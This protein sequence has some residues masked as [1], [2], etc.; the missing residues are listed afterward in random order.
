MQESAFVD[1]ARKLFILMYKVSIPSALFCQG[2]KKL[3]Q[4][5]S[6]QFTKLI[7][8]CGFFWPYSGVNWNSC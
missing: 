2:H 5:T 7:S 1:Y 6:C 3:E 4:N 8:G